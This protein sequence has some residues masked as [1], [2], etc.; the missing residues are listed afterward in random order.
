MKTTGGQAWLKNS[1]KIKYLYRRPLLVWAGLI[2][3]SH[4][5][6]A[7]PDYISYHRKISS[8]SLLIFHGHEREALEQFDSLFQGYE[9]MYAEHLYMGTQLAA[10][11]GHENRAYTYLLRLCHLGVS[12]RLLLADSLIGRLQRLNPQRWDSVFAAY[13]EIDA[14]YRQ[15]ISGAY[16]VMVDSILQVDQRLTW[17]INNPRWLLP[18]DWL[19]WKRQNKRHIRVL[20]PMIR[21]QGYPGERIVGLS[22]YVA[23]LDSTKKIRYGQNTFILSRKMLVLLLHYFSSKRKDL[24]DELLA[25]V[26]A[27]H[28]TVFDYASVNDFLARSRRRYRTFY[29]SVWNPAPEKWNTYIQANRE[30]LGLCSLEQKKAYVKYWDELCKARQEHTAVYLPALYH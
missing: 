17:H 28:M 7:Q 25:Q 1:G 27:G 24:N 6:S 13:D 12:R 14:Q 22:R 23:E 10:R 30:A 18:F 5:L 11:L 20:L 19:R 21:A 9:R 4:H 29:C 16:A 26:K 8:V 3:F 15:R 2:L